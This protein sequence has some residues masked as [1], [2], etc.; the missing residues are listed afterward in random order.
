M[1]TD[2]KSFVLYCDLIHTVKKLP[3]EKAGEL[4]LT[5]LKYVNDENPTVTDLTVD[6]VFEP[7]KQQLKR[8]LKKYEGRK[9]AKSEAGKLGNLKR[10]YSDIY[11]NVIS[12]KI[13]LDEG[14]KLAKTRKD[15]HTDAKLAVNVNDNVTVND[16]VNDINKKDFFN[17]ED[18]I[19]WFNECRKYLNLK[20]NIKRL[21]QYE[22][23]D[24][25][26]LVKDY[27]KEDFKKAFKSFSVDEYYLNNN[28]IFPKYFLKQETF[29]RFLNTD[30]KQVAKQNTGGDVNLW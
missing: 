28:L 9:G 22:K 7:I 30:V 3:P 23:A 11:D 18:F 15:S 6:L 24:F 4:L 17:S 19:N 21:S 1:A 14:L 29:I 26:E 5:I 20:S 12:E 8:D 13:T 16:N 27:T 25:N 2:K 10:Y